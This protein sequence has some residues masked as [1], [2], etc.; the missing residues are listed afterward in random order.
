MSNGDDLVPKHPVSHLHDQQS[1]I[2]KASFVNH[3][4]KRGWLGRSK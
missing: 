1:A 2:P 3:L 4:V